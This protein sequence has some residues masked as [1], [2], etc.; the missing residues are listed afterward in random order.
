MESG[1]TRWTLDQHQLRY[2][3][4][5]DARMRAGNLRRNYDVILIQ[6][7][8]V[9][10]LRE[11]H[12][13]DEMPPEY[14]GGLAENGVQA[15]KQFVEEGG[16]LVV[17]EEATEFAIDLFGLGAKNAVAGLRNTEFYVP[18]SIMR[19]EVD[20][21]NPLARGVKPNNAAWFSDASRAFDLSDSNIRVV[22][23]YGSGNPALSGW[24]LGPDKVAGKAALIEATVGRGSVVLFGFQPDYRSQTV[25]T[26]PLLF[27]ALAVQR[28]AGVDGRNDR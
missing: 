22:A 9:Q 26:W 13:A 23:R 20:A 24:I 25:A 17:I 21:S 3:T 27:N 7:H 1:W 10:A 14:V 5:S 12:R 16:R 6:T 4:V 15:I 11:G 2:D 8:P 28:G 18:G 19:L